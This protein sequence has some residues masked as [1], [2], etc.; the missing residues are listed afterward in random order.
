MKKGQCK[1]DVVRDSFK[2]P[3]LSKADDV[4]EK[5]EDEVESRGELKT[6][7]EA[8]ILDLFEKAS[9][10][11]SVCGATSEGNQKGFADKKS[12]FNQSGGPKDAPKE[13]AEAIAALKVGCVCKKGL[14]PESPN[15]DAYCVYRVDQIGIYG[16]FDGHGPYGH[17]VSNFVQEK[18]PRAFVEDRDFKDN[19]EQALST[20]FEAT[21]RLCT[22]S[23][24]AGHFDCTLSGTTATMALQRDGKLHVAHVGDSRAVL[25]K[26]PPQGGDKFMSETITADHKPGDNPV[27]RDRIIKAGGQVKRLEGDIPHRVFVS[28]K[29]YPGLA[30]TR[31]IGDTVG[32]T[33]GVTCTPE[34]KTLQIEKD[35]R[36][37]LLCSDGIWEFIDSQEAVDI[38]SRYQ[39]AD[40]HKAAEA[41]ASEAWNRWILEEQNVVDDITVIVAWFFED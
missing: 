34:V 17:D 7:R 21:H 15:Q 27:E 38:V 5:S 33:A 4:L 18:L 16:V 32:C 26:A 1:E 8:T 28:G 37:L 36:F 22:E 11:V 3:P 19:P 20:S 6:G 14:K 23:Q 13:Q 9:R 25:A 10:K 24:T 40:A 35:W 31:S 12:E 29:L 39:A 30:M 41:L 2:R